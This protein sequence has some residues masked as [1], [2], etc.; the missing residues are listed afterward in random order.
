MLVVV[1]V[2][3]MQPK[4]TLRLGG[5]PQRCRATLPLPDPSTEGGGVDWGTAGRRPLQPGDPWGALQAVEEN[6]A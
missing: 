2:R 4:I 3:R 5:G 1:G 6:V